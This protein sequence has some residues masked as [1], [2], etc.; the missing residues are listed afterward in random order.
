MSIHLS[1]HVLILSQKKTKKVLIKTRYNEFFTPNNLVPNIIEENNTI[2]NG[3]FYLSQFS[4]W[5]VVRSFVLVQTINFVF[6][7]F[8]IFHKNR[9]TMEL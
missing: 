1:L 5:K 4:Q 9:V 7:Y 8:V 3:D 6:W 2:A